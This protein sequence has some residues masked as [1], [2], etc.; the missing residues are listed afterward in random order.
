MENLFLFLATS[1]VLRQAVPRFKRYIVCPGCSTLLN[2]GSKKLHIRHTKE[3]DKLYFNDYSSDGVTYGMICVEMS[4]QF[5][6][7]QAE[8]ILLHYIS[9]VRRP[10][11]ISHNVSMDLAYENATITITDYWQDSAGTDWK[12]KGYTNGK[13]VAVLYV[14]NISDAAV[15]NHDTY[16]DGF[17]FFN[18]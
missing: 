14:K 17:R 8:D 5:T 11:H 16:L 15:K 10:L 2:T 6:L 9:R 4:D 18:S 7:H 1:L 12:V 3:G 13:V